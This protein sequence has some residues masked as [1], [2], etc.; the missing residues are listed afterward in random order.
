VSDVLV[1]HRWIA[2]RVT[3]ILGNEDDV[4]TELCFN[5]IEGSR[6]VSFASRCFR[7]RVALD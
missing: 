5:L 4:V 6:Y 3:E 1:L 2:E 7:R